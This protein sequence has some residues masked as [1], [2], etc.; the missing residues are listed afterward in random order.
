[1]RKNQ[2]IHPKAL[3]DLEFDQILS[4]IAVY[5]QSDEAKKKTLNITPEFDKLEIINKLNLTNE[6]LSSLESDNPLP[7]HYINPFVNDLK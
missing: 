6:Y 3:Q 2:S 7:Y 1:M 4:N 5:A